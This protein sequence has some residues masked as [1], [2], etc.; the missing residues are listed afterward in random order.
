M[1]VQNV[2]RMQVVAIGF[3]AALFFASA[4]PAQEISNTEWPDGKDVVTAGN[5]ATA[6]A[7]AQ[8][9]GAA[10]AQVANSNATANTPAVNQQAAAAQQTPIEGNWMT[11][12]LVICFA[13]LTLYALAGTRRGDR[14]RYAG[15][16]N[17]FR[18][19]SLS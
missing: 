18:S 7:A 3:A 1:K 2:I 17:A 13:L 5:A 9:N 14:N 15:A 10:D 11:T 4:A 12:S 19:T 8:P 6:Q 16:G